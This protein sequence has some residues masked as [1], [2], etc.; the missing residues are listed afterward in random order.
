MDAE[1]RFTEESVTYALNH[2]ASTVTEDTVESW[3]DGFPTAS[4]EEN[5]SPED[6]LWVGVVNSGQTPGDGFRELVAV[7]LSG[8]RYVGTR[9]DASPHLL[10]AFV[11]DL[12]SRLDDVPASFAPVDVLIERADGIIAEPNDDEEEDALRALCQE[13]G[14][15][16]SR[17]LIRSASF[18]V[19]LLDGNESEEEREDLSE[20]MLLHQ[21]FGRRRTAVVWAPE[22]MSPD[23]Y[24]QAMAQ[25]RAV[26]PAH[27][28]TPGALQMQQ[29][30]LE[31]RDAPHAYAAG[32]EFLISR[33]SPEPQ[34]PGHV[35]WSEYDDLSDAADWIA[36]T[37]APLHAV[38]AR[39]PLHARLQDA[40]PQGI[41][42]LAPG[43]VHRPTLDDAEGA[44]LRS[45]LLTLVS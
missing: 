30:F 20:D 15:S 24:F 28:D 45:F 44:E 21:G 19:A 22:G 14:V 31:A 26:F 40:V 13:E 37:D 43:R 11:D 29:A 5:A 27:E 35:R 38:I 41:P 8:S 3:M 39:E 10:P 1:N 2:F 17:H 18:S 32:L 7:L 42:L 25:F 36:S 9:P 23:P 34:S 16:A 12:K 4:P 6:Q 33:G